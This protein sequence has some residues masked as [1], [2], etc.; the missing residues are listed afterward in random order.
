MVNNDTIAV[1]NAEDALED[2][3]KVQRAI[4]TNC[5]KQPIDGNN[6]YHDILAARRCNLEPFFNTLVI[7]FILN[8]D[9]NTPQLQF[10]SSFCTGKT[11]LEM[12]QEISQ[13]TQNNNTFADFICPRVNLLPAEKIV[14]AATLLRSEIK[15]NLGWLTWMVLPKKSYKKL[16][17]VSAIQDDNELLTYMR[18]QWRL[19][20]LK[21]SVVFTS[22]PMVLIT[23]LYEKMYYK[24]EYINTAIAPSTFAHYGLDKAFFSQNSFPLHSPA[25]ALQANLENTEI[26][27]TNDLSWLQEGQKATSTREQKLI[28]AQRNLPQ[29]LFDMR[30]KLSAHIDKIEGDL[31][32]CCGFYRSKARQAKITALTNILKHFDSRSFDVDGFRCALSSYRSKDIFASIGKSKTKELID[33]LDTFSQHATH[34]M[35]T[36]DVGAIEV[37]SYLSM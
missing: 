17:T 3:Q 20:N 11:A 27:L 5:S 36:N 32:G 18:E 24:K 15:A 2:I 4:Y 19:K 28:E 37:P 29:N 21:A 25:K 8:Y 34:Y 12:R 26:G 1:V 10:F 9:P 7:D 6:I 31:N 33:E 16:E 14:A 30:D 13:V 22:G 23:T 35:L